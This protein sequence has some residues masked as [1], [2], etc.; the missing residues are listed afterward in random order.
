V[1]KC[2]N[3][4]L[5]HVCVCVCVKAASGAAAHLA[6]CHSQLR[7][8]GRNRCHASL[9]CIV[10]HTSAPINDRGRCQHMAC[11]S[12]RHKSGKK[13]ASVP[14]AV[15]TLPPPTWVALAVAVIALPTSVALI[16]AILQSSG[17]QGAGMQGGNTQRKFGMLCSRRT[18]CPAAAA[19]ANVCWQA[20]SHLSTIQARR[21]SHLLKWLLTVWASHACIDA[22]R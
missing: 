2:N 5:C 9:H 6:G 12:C 16:H 15:L 17:R 21:S 19:D 18:L 20:G 10:L 7:C 13:C 11:P 22:S 4:G 8:G 3:A 14:A 1:W